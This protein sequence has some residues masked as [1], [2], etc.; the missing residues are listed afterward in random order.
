MMDK[1]INPAWRRKTAA[2]QP[3][4]AFHADDTETIEIEERQRII[5]FLLHAVD[6]E[7]VIDD[8]CKVLNERGQSSFLCH[9]DETQNEPHSYF[10]T[11]LD[12]EN[13]NGEYCLLP[14]ISPQTVLTQQ[15]DHLVMLVPAHLDAVRAAYRKIKQLSESASP[16]IGIVIVGPRD[17]HAAWRYFRKLGV[18]TLRYLDIPLLNLGFLPA[19]V[20][21]EH[22]PANQHRQTFLARISERLARSEFFCQRGSSN[23]ENTP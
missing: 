22:D 3:T 10:G 1:Q 11:R 4:S 23:R 19:Q 17:Q 16:E 8:L 15:F 20:T 9:I 7:W 6:Q 5:P 2:S 12:S 18:G 14:V 13:S 21:P